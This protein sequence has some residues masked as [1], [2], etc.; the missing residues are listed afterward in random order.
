MRYVSSL[1]P[2]YIKII[3]TTH[4]HSVSYFRQTFRTYPV[5]F[6][7]VII[8]IDTSCNEWLIITGYSGEQWGKK[9]F[10]LI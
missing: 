3:Y 1:L 5:F 2:E 6:L 10:K 7:P 8:N 4:L 9:R